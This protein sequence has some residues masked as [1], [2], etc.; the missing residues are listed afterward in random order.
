[1]IDISI[2]ELRNALEESVKLQSFYAKLL[3]QYDGGLRLKFANADEWISRLRACRAGN[4]AADAAA[5]EETECQTC[6]GLGA[7]SWGTKCHW[8]AGS[9]RMK[10]P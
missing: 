4:G 7:D 1:M 9:G 8:C 2:D 6:H 3:N 10:A 5:R